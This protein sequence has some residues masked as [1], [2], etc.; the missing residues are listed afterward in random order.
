MS[1]EARRIRR[2]AERE[3]I[4]RVR[5]GALRAVK[6]QGCCC[7]PIVHVNRLPSGVFHTSVAHDDFCPLLRIMVERGPIENRRQIVLMLPD[8]EEQR[9]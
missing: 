6:V 3:A 5:T 2:A 8:A 1:R 9:A 7:R 4:K